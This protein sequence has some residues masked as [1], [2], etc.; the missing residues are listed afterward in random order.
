MPDGHRGW[1]SSRAIKEAI[2]NRES[3]SRPVE[4]P[5]SAPETSQPS[6]SPKPVEHKAQK[7]TQP[8]RQ[9]SPTPLV[10]QVPPTH[11]PKTVHKDHAKHVAR[12]LPPK[13][14]PQTSK[15]ASQ[16]LVNL[17]VPARS[18]NPHIRELS[19]GPYAESHLSA[20]TPGWLSSVHCEDSPDLSWLSR[21]SLLGPM[22]LVSEK[23]GPWRLRR[24]R[25][26][27]PSLRSCK[28]RLRSASFWTALLRAFLTVPRYFIS[29][30]QRLA[31]VFTGRTGCYPLAGTAVI[32]TGYGLTTALLSLM[33][34]SS[35]FAPC[36]NRDTTSPT[37]C[38][39]S[40]SL[41][42]SHVGSGCWRFSS[43]LKMF[44]PN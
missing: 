17:W 28:R 37:F 11:R 10:E 5:G 16:Y 25:L 35:I 13:R 22:P 42:V 14:K 36:L 34:S 39:A 6:E 1:P 44:Q 21:R 26:N 33:W 30:S 27:S 8:V 18:A 9:L 23:L 7:A 40:S 31:A 41:R 43:S 2:A 32:E 38:C 29:A 24:Q 15:A 19:A 12:E 3:L 4:Q 20:A